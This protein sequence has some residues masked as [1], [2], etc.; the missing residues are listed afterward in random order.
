M[1]A[2]TKTIAKDRTIKTY[3]ALFLFSFELSLI[4]GPY[5]MV[6]VKKCWWLFLRVIRIN[7]LLWGVSIMR[8]RCH[9][10]RA[11]V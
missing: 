9:H 10:M 2:A 3:A 7:Q 11:T 6:E 1:A 5:A 8:N 4:A